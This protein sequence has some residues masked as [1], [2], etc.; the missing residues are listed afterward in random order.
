MTGLLQDLR[1]GMR[2]FRN[3]PTFAAVA[4][5]AAVGIYGVLSDVVSQ[6]TRE[7]GLRVAL[8]AR[9]F[10][11]LSLI[12][13][14]GGKLALIGAGVGV[15]AALC[16]TRFMASLLYGVGTTNPV[17]FAAAAALLLVVA[18]TAFYIPARRAAKVD[19]IVALRYE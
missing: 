5:L 6:R 17:T 19:P 18:L 7:I 14:G 10:D 8:G 4:V 13:R 1:H 15:L 16:L 3:R 11:V 2:T 12:L 9:P